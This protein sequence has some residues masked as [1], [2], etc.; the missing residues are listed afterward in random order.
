MFT[1][2]PSL[3]HSSIITLINWNLEY[4]LLSAYSF[5]W[6]SSHI[7]STWTHYYLSSSLF[8]QQKGQFMG[9]KQLTKKT[10]N[11]ASL[12]RKQVQKSLPNSECGVLILPSWR[13]TCCRMEE[14]QAKGDCFRADWQKLEQRYWSATAWKSLDRV[15]MR[16]SWKSVDGLQREVEGLQLCS[17]EEHVAWNER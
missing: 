13:T 11:I 15:R 3:F 10:Q 4:V 12:E 16:L 8:S 5:T 1:R 6:N 9:I 2:L 14:L 17:P 7:Y